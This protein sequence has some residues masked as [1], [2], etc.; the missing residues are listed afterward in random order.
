LVLGFYLV[1]PEAV[2]DAL[3]TIAQNVEYLSSPY[4][5]SRTANF[6]AGYPAKGK[7]R[8]NPAITAKKS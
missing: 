4:L 6:L 5:V 3:K 2:F 7:R 1:A 8:H